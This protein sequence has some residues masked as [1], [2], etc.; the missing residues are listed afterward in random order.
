[1][2]LVAGAEKA[3]SDDEDLELIVRAEELGFSEFWIGEHHTMKYE[4]IV[5][6]EIFIA[7]G[8]RMLGFQVRVAL[9]AHLQKLS[10]AFHIVFAAAGVA[11]PVL[12]VLSDLKGRRTG[13]SDYVRLSQKLAKGTVKVT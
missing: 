4:N 8:G 11:L 9:Y 5:M 12:M 6:P 13:D 3:Q 1:M 7:R 2:E 10:L